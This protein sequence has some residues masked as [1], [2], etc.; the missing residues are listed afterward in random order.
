MRKAPR[1]R[2]ENRISVA[3]SFQHLVSAHVGH[4]AMGS[5]Y[6]CSER[7][8]PA[9]FPMPRGPRMIGERLRERLATCGRNSCAATLP[10]YADV[11]D[12]KQLKLGPGRRVDE[13]ACRHRQRCSRFSLPRPTRDRGQLHRPVTGS[14]RARRPKSGMRNDVGR[15]PYSVHFHEDDFAVS[16]GISYCARAD[17]RPYPTNRVRHVCSP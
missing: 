4:P 16:A 1:F 12:S 13:A 7:A 17:R 14:D 11:D 10:A 2:R 6:V 15:T 8:G 9:G 3:F 5:R